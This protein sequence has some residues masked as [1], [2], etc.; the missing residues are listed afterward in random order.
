MTHR[1]GDIKKSFN[2]LLESTGAPGQRVRSRIDKNSP[3]NLYAALTFPHKRVLLEIGPV[4]KAYLPEGFTRPRIKGLNITVDSDNSL[5]EVTLLLELEQIEAIDVFVIFVTR[6][7][8]EMDNLK[9]SA[10]AVRA[11]IALV[12]RWRDFF[13][14]NSELL[15]DERQTGL[16]GELYLMASL[17]QSRIP[18]SHLVKAWTG[19]RRTN[20]DYEFGGLSIEVKSTAAVDATTVNITNILQ[21]DDTGLDSLFLCH[22]LLDARQGNEKTLPILI[23]FLSSAVATHAP[24]M[25][26]DFEEKV[27][28]TKYRREHEGHYSNRSYTERAIEFYQVVDDFPRLLEI[29]LPT[30]ITKASYEITLQ[31]CK[32]FVKM[33]EEVVTIMREHCD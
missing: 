28:L 27:L 15:S 10:D 17:Y 5:G 20:Q 30:G 33:R 3:I 16:Y 2:N 23:E 22:V 13:S 32:P 8:E 4:K 12:E 26:L 11:V 14:G 7:C 31:N 18:I 25:E 24:E 29:D 19:S 9:K 1:Q 21:L 6:V